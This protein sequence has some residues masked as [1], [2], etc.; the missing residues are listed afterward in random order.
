[1]QWCCGSLPV[2]MR[3][4]NIFFL[5]RRSISNLPFTLKTY[6]LHMS[7]D[8]ICALDFAS[9]DEMIDIVHVGYSGN[10]SFGNSR[11]SCIELMCRVIIVC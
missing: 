1:M 5:M 4:E 11:I 3:A 6:E 9:H 10:E 8:V 2:A 7:I